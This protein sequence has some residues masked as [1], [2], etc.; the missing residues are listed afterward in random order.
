M[1]RKCTGKKLMENMMTTAMSILATFLRV[2][3]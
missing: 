3:S 1:G 2:R